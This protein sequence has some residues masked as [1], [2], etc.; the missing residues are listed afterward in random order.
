MGQDGR[1]TTPSDR[2]LAEVVR[3]AQAGDAET[4]GRLLQD[5]RPY[6]LRIANAELPA[7]LV[8]KAGPSDVVQ[9]TL[10]EALSCFARFRGQSAAELQG[11]LRT[12]LLRQVAQATQ[13]YAATRKRQVER[14]DVLPAEALAAA[15]SSPS[16][17]AARQEQVEAVRRVLERLP[18]HYRQVLVWREWEELPFAEIAARMGRS[19]DAVRMLWWRGLERFNAEMGIR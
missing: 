8:P 5:F 11:W 17:H 2:D 3:A 15:Q 1:L 18:E 19:V 6:L 4:L 10:V 13:H 16:S 12:I 9:E 14:E 7:W